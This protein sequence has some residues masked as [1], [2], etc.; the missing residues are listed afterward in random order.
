MIRRFEEGNHDSPTEPMRTRNVS[1]IENY[2]REN[3]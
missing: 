1:R 2:I 3:I